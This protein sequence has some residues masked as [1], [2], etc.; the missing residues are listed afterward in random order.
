MPRSS[1]KKPGGDDIVGFDTRRFGRRAGMQVL[2][3]AKPN[4][5]WLYRFGPIIAFLIFALIILLP[6][7]QKYGTPVNRTRIANVKLVKDA[8]DRFHNDRHVYP[9][10]LGPGPVDALS[11]DLVQGGYLKEIPAATDG[12]QFIYMSDGRYMYGLLVQLKEEGSL[13]T[14]K[15]GGLCVTGN[16]IKGSGAWGNPPE[17]KF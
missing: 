7:P 2:K 15:L 13:M 9:K 17:C 4:T 8:I 11:A 12:F 14:E 5:D 16:G 1:A 3:M 10:P 6:I